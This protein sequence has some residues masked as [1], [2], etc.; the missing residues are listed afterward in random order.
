LQRARHILAKLFTSVRLHRAAHTPP[1]PRSHTSLPAPLEGDLP[2]FPGCS[3]S[4][5]RHQDTDTSR[6]TSTRAEPYRSEPH[7]PAAATA[8]EDVAEA[9]RGEVAGA[10]DSDRADAPVERAFVDGRL[11]A[12]ET[13]NR[14]CSPVVEVDLPP[15]LASTSAIGLSWQSDLLLVASVGDT[16]FVAVA[17]APRR[18]G[19][20]VR[21]RRWRPRHGRGAAT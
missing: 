15:G 3:T 5:A 9:L 2:A 4:M 18:T 1:L 12:I 17:F 6:A 19:A 14:W 16:R 10:D 21:Q 20:A 11:D 7:A 8:D 13:W